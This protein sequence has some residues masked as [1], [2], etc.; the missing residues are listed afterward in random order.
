[1]D[2]LKDIV[3]QYWG[4]D[5][6]LPL[7]HEA[8]ECVIEG[9]DS[10]VILP[11]GGGKSLCFQAPAM[12]MEGMAVVVSP[13]LS[14]MKDQ[15]DALRTNG[16]PAA[17]IDSTMTGAERE[18]V[19][20]A[21]Q[22]KELKL[23]YVSPERMAQQAFAEYL[24]DAGLSF[25]VVDEAH[26]ISQWGHDFRPEY[27]ELRRLREV[28]PGKAIHAYTATATP[29]VRDDI[30]QELCLRDPAILTGSFDRPNLVYRVA[31]RSDGFAQVCRVIDAH[32]GESGIIYCIRRADVD[33]LSEQLAGKG[34][35]ALPY[36]AGMDDAARKRN[37]EAFSREEADI[38]VATVAFGMG[39][40]KSNVRYIVH[41][42]MPKSIEHYH[43]ETGR[44][45]RDGLAA[46]CWLLYSYSDFRVWQSILQKSEGEAAA[47][48]LDKLRDL[49][50]Y[51]EG[52][53]CRHKS[54]VTYFG[55]TYGDTG[56]GACDVCLK[57]MDAVEESASI[58]QAILSCVAQLGAIAGP[59]Y[60]T[61]VLTGTREDRVL[62]KGHDRLTEFGA[63]ESSGSR[64]V[65]DWIE[66]LVQQGCLEKT[67]EYNVLAL[68]PRG[69]AA[70]RGE[71]GAQLLKAS[72]RGTQTKLGKRGGGTAEALLS[73]APLAGFDLE[74][75]ETL[76]R[77]RRAKAGE[78]GV[79]PFV[80]FGDAALRDMARK[81]PTDTQAFL[82]V[83]G[84]GAYKCDTFGDYFV[85]V[86][87]EFLEVH[88]DAAPRDGA[89]EEPP[90]PR[91]AKTPKNDTFRRAA[92]LFARGVSLPEA[93]EALNRRPGTLG[94]YLAEY[95]RANAIVDPSPWVE[96]VV[97]EKVKEAVEAVG[98]DRLRPIFDYLD[99]QVPYET[100]RVC[101]ACL[102]NAGV[103][104]DDTDEGEPS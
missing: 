80:V 36:H 98:A 97:A 104:E 43:Q 96:P 30:R 65:R 103:I 11:T 100:I 32:R 1:M 48:A 75:F 62:A 73:A 95:I 31:K 58:A 86:I 45:G 66:Q 41:A 92:E 18:S 84:V 49:L 90:K 102:R 81:K 9:R 35:K 67:G 74:L 93:S 99:G 55:Q 26:C 44:A 39:I 46:D 91:R 54:L 83:S 5:E 50:R 24:R 38:V 34:H 12:A 6:F 21:I 57:Q 79:P 63:L 13:L 59:T 76:R 8:M 37:Q 68:T 71:Y 82:G 42:A 23:L 7:Q 51:C 72:G 22:A 69:A 89:A 19:H 3:K 64:A 47:V 70:L 53:A 4:Y 15:V 77:A 33:S 2:T 29:H 25:L 28:F 85:E 56:C 87:R 16:V 14:L 61:L 20:R 10:V 17:K 60:T 88:P 101:I 40:D 27:R 52:V 94:D 78:L